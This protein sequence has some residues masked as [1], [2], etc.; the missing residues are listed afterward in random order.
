MRA[1]PAAG[2]RLPSETE[3]EYAARAGGAVADTSSDRSHP[4]P[5]GEGQPGQ[6]GLYDMSGNVWEWCS[7]LLAPYPYREE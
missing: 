6:L 4:R 1:F 5:A 7:S 3:W 2:F